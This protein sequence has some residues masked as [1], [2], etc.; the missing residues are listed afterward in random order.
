MYNAD[1]TPRYLLDPAVP[2]RVGSLLPEARIVVI[3]RGEQAQL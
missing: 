1:I 3:L 2:L